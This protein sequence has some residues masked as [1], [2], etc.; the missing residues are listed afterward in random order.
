MVAQSV[1]PV[2]QVPFEVLFDNQYPDLMRFAIRLTGD[3]PVAEDIVADVFARLLAQRRPREIENVGA[4]LR[5]CVVNEAR[6]RWRRQERRTR[7][8]PKALHSPEA[9]G[10]GTGVVDERDRV[11]DAIARLSPRQRAVVVLR[12]YED[13]SEADTAEILGMAP[14]TVKS[15]LAAARR[16]LQSLLEGD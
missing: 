4:Y 16:H 10:D 8:L 1:E 5:R 15:T 7:L 3:R 9:V 14:G 13:H 11:L 12:F 6:S 2:R